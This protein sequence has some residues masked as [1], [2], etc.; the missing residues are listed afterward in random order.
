M[1]FERILQ[2]IV[3]DCGGGFGAALMGL[4]G[5]AIAQVASKGPVDRDDPFG[6][7]V[8]S[9]GIEFGRIL[10]ET[11]KASDALGAGDL[12]F[13]RRGDSRALHS[14]PFPP[15]SSQRASG[16]DGLASQA[17]LARRRGSCSELGELPRTAT[18]SHVRRRAGRRDRN[19][20]RRARAR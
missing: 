18:L 11:S 4:D 6:G 15:G 2:A 10:A 16:I 14:H 12:Q 5:I 3:D 7:D 20:R 1:S 13:V 17:L 9:A 19:S 8:T